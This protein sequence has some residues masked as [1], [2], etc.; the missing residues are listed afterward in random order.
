VK[1]SAEVCD[2]LDNDCDGVIDGPTAPPGPYTPNTGSWTLV[3]GG[4]WESG[5]KSGWDDIAPHLGV[6]KPSSANAARGSWSALA[7]TKQAFDGAGYSLGR[8]IP[9]TPGETYV[10]SG[11]FYTQGVSEGA[12]YL[13]L[14]DVPF[15]SNM[16]IPMNY[17]GWQ[18]MYRTFA[19]PSGY[20]SVT[21]RLVRDG[22]G[23]APNQPV[24]IDE[25]GVTL[26]SD[27]V[28]PRRMCGPVT[29]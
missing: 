26:E 5:N 4:D 23:V 9:V 21:V 17:Q 22:G 13:D 15:E 28:P 11:F 25:V 7:M 16:G 29:L 27:F 20:T 3:P 8:A 18:F 24:Y 12:L 1:P 2:G 14:N 6:F 10:L 19:V